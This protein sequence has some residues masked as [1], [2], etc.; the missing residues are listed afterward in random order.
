MVRVAH[1]RQAVTAATHHVTIEPIR[2]VRTA[3]TRHRRL[4]TIRLLAT[5]LHETTRHMTTAML[6]H[7]AVTT[8]TRRRMRI[9][10]RHET[11][12]TRHGR[13]STTPIRAETTRRSVTIHHRRL[14]EACFRH[15]QATV[16]AVDTH[17]H[18]AAT[19]PILVAEN[20]LRDSGHSKIATVCVCVCSP[21]NRSRFAGYESQGG[22]GFG[23]R[24]GYGCVMMMYGVNQEDYNCDKVF[25]L[26]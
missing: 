4:A 8:A 13:T 21:N 2:H 22:R 3:D 19:T 1:R 16:M 20:R 15:Q 23:D 12:A 24:A 6:R 9:A 14:A 17:R 18:A 25:N 5:T 10:I 26:L 11:V 7:R